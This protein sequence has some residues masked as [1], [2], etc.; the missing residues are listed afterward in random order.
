MDFMFLPL[1]HKINV[2]E[3][4]SNFLFIIWTVNIRSKEIEK[5]TLI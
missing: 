5:Q 1:K 2:F 4:T 3:L